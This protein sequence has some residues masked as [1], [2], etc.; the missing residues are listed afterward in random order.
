MDR[1]GRI[2][3][4]VLLAVLLTSCISLEA[5]IDVRRENRIRVDLVYT[6]PNELWNAGVFDEETHFRAIPLT[7]SDALRIARTSRS[8]LRRYR[9]RSG[10]EVTVVSMRFRPRDAAALSALFGGT[11]DLG[12]SSLTITFAAGGTPYTDAEREVVEGVAGDNV[13]AFSL[14]HP[15][16]LVRSD[17]SGTLS[18]DPS[19]VVTIPLRD[20]L[21]S[22][23]PVTWTLSWE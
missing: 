19:A 6:V 11:V 9:V 17:L 4:A 20:V 18:G 5:T 8:E 21:L 2:S 16:R 23:D 13:V 22:E 1:V 3:G 12:P 7:R 14:R 10:E 15:G